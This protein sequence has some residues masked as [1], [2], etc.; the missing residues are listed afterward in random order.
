V[1][2]Q[3]YKQEPTIAREILEKIRQSS[4]FSSLYRA[5]PQQTNNL[6]KALELL[7]GSKKANNIPAI[8][9]KLVNF[10]SSCNNFSQ[11]PIK[12]QKE[13]KSSIFMYEN[14]LENI[15]K[16]LQILE[17]GLKIKI[18]ITCALDC[19]TLNRTS[20][21]INSLEE[22]IKQYK[23]E[24]SPNFFSLAKSNKKE[25]II[26]QELKDICTM[27][28]SQIGSPETMPKGLLINLVMH[29]HQA[30]QNC[31]KHNS[32]ELSNHIQNEICQIQ[33]KQPEL[34]QAGEDLHKAIANYQ[35][36]KP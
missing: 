26:A 23:G 13:I 34:A 35:P 27:I 12:E 7:E 20:S 19:Y 2:K 29:L 17:H 21:L 14:N 1:S 31:E 16:H 9:S 18:K 33:Q 32:T 6:L 30:F 10:R 24:T 15:I 36:Q 28:R 4:I 3:S 5:Y 22:F 25:I 11:A 8:L